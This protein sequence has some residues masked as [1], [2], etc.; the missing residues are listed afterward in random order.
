MVE[1]RYRDRYEAAAL[2]GKHIGEVREQ[3]RSGFSIPDKARA[4]LNGNKISGKHEPKTT[5]SENDKLSFEDRSR[6]GLF[7]AGA[8]MLALV[9][10]G[11]GYA[12]AYLTATTAV[13]V[14]AAGDEIATA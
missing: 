13:D 2:A 8:V 11:G 14:T 7:F 12:Y 5:L 9:I 3:Y 1:I 10:T 6:R 4:R